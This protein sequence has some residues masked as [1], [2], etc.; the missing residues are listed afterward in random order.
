MIYHGANKQSYILKCLEVVHGLN[1][2]NFKKL[3]LQKKWISSLILFCNLLLLSSNYTKANNLTIGVPTKPSNTTLQFTVQWDNSWRLAPGSGAGNWDAVWLFVKYQDCANN[4]WRHVNLSTTV[5]DHTI[6]GS[7]LE[8]ITVADARGVYL[9]LNTNTITSVSSAVITLKFATLVDAGYN[10]Q[11]FGIEMVN[12]PTNSFVIGDCTGGTN[13]YGF[14]CQWLTAATQT[15]GLAYNSYFSNNW[16]ATLNSSY[17]MGVNSF[18]CMKYEIC[19]EQYAAFL[20]TLTYDQQAVCSAALPNSAPGTLALAPNTNGRN[21]IRIATSGSLSNV[22]AVYGCN[23]NNNG[24]LNEAADGQNIACN[25]L[26]WSDL[27]AYLDWAALRPMTEFEYEKVCRGNQSQV[28][29]EYVWGVPAAQP[30]PPP[31]TQAI[32]SALTNAGASNELSTA[33]GN[34]LCAYGANNAALGPLR[35][36]FAATNATSRIQAGSSYYGCMDM[37]GNV[38]EQ[39]VGG[40]NIGATNFGFTGV[41]GDGLLATTG[42]AN[43]AGW[44]AWGGVGG[45]G[46][47]R[48]GDW[49]TT[50]ARPLQTS[51]R[52]NIG[53]YVNLNQTRDLRIGGRGVR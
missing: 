1:S 14:F 22:P 3:N 34:G 43:T 18:Y 15:A 11:V 25:Y 36:G 40:I 12:V 50:D 2:H 23:L 47:M 41:L 49:F 4:L 10:Y 24:T 9:R 33:T 53:T 31:I 16:G 37:A 19:Q 20:N 52:W 42:Y 30:S 26:Q 45:G 6:G 13:G 28:V 8:A 17:P 44:P 29:N 7:Q 35:C 48:G 21:G 51:D 32:S 27:M 5:G 39:C 38:W 46:I